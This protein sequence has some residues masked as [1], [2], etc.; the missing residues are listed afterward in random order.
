[1][2]KFVFVIEEGVI[3]SRPLDKV[4]DEIYYE[5]HEEALEALNAE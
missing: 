4:K 2:I 1:M 3:W 5:T